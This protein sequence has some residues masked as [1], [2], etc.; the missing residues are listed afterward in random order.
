[1]K[2]VLHLIAED[3]AGLED[4]FAAEAESVWAWFAVWS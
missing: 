1:M 2:G 3:L 4:W